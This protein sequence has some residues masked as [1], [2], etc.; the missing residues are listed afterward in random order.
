MTNGP[1]P[2][3][4]LCGPVGVGKTTTAFEIFG[5]LTDAGIKTA[6]VDLDQLGLCYPTPA[7]DRDNHRVK[8]ANLAAVWPGFR[9]DGARCLVV[10]GGIG[11][12]DVVR[13]HA[14]QLPDTALTLVRLRVS[15][16]GLRRRVIGRGWQVDAV[17]EFIREA[18]DL[19]QHDFAH[20][21][22]DTDDLSVAD[23]AT[24]VLAKAGGWPC[25]S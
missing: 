1:I 19:D 5:R 18:H 16:D 12:H 6:Y 8:A 9:D 20:A 13:L 3:L 4:W 15:D 17:D 23:V 25:L 24:A 2:F 7:D 22:V 14:D 21:Y 11:T 10:S